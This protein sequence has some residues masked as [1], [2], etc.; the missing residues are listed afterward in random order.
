MTQDKH[1]KCGIIGLGR[2]ASL[3]E[4]DELRSKP[5]THAAFYA[6]DPQCVLICGADIAQEKREAFAIDWGIAPEKIYKDYEAMLKSESLDLVSIC[7]YAPD[8]L[9][10]CKAA[11]EAGARGLWIEKTLGCSLNEAQ[12]I[13]ALIDK[14]G[15]K[16]VVDYPRRAW[17]PYRKVKRLIEEKTFGSLQSV[18]C[19]MTHQLLHTGT[20]AYDIL[21]Y[22]CG[23]AVGISGKLEDGFQGSQI[24]DQGGVGQIEMESGTTAFVAAKKKRYYIF[25]FDLIFD[26]ARILL[27]NDI[28][29]IYLPDKSKI[30][31][32][33]KEL[34]ESCEFSW[35]EPNQAN[36]LEDLKHAIEHNKQPLSSVHNAIESL[37]I[38]LG[39]FYSHQ[40]NSTWI[41]PDTIP[42]DF[43]IPNR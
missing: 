18:T 42:E 38:G 7:A 17:G 16:A 25:Q 12:S 1:L 27:G 39:I 31:S 19:H 34:F 9:A 3:L 33:F 43:H 20:H 11:L 14:C 8:R 2:I 13:G 23:E 36:L 30:Y 21:R 5:C 40:N 10:M 28:Q 24:S 26:N 35:D 6:R 22:W 32:G 29:K 4:K 15:A 37:R 41:Q